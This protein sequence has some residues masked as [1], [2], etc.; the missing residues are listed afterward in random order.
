[1]DASRVQ[2]VL[3][4]LHRLAP[5][6]D[7]DPALAVLRAAILL[8]DALGVVLTDDDLRRPELDEPLLRRRLEVS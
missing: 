8:E 7:D 3:R 1:M 4:E 5:R 2:E 6:D